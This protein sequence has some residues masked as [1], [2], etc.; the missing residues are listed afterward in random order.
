MGMVGMTGQ[1][2]KSMAIV[3]KPAGDGCNLHCRYCYVDG[4]PQRIRLMPA[5]VMV[6]MHVLAS[7]Y[8][9]TVNMSWHG[10]EP[11]LAGMDFYRDVVETQKRLVEQGTKFTNNVQSNFTLMTREFARLFRE[12]GFTVGTS[13]D[14]MAEIHDR[15]RTYPCGKGTHADVMRGI[16]VARGEGLGVGVLAAYS[17]PMLGREM[18]VYDF[19]KEHGLPWTLNPLAKSGR[20][21]ETDARHLRCRI[22]ALKADD[23]PDRLYGPAVRARDRLFVA[24]RIW[25]PNAGA[26]PIGFRSRAGCPAS[27]LSALGCTF[28]P[29]CS[30]WLR[31][32]VIA[33]ITMSLAAGKSH[34]VQPGMKCRLKPND[35][36]SRLLMLSTVM[37]L[38]LVVTLI[39][40]QGRGCGPCFASLPYWMVGELTPVRKSIIPSAVNQLPRDVHRRP[41]SPQPLTSPNQPSS[42]PREYESS[43]DFAPLAGKAG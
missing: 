26:P 25:S 24:L 2:R 39:A 14:G 30:V 1:K 28:A 27:R 29:S 12:N 36:P 3:A 8:A 16:E 7:G 5:G 34:F 41:P 19:M 23:A 43:G 37:R 32:W 18:E 17:R 21:E 9:E 6:N 22:S 13:L 10:G 40:N 31:P 38:S 11:L 35:A 15:L 42:L 33:S 4:E 20:G